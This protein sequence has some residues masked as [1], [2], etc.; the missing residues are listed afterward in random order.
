MILAYVQ[1]IKSENL[2]SLLHFLKNCMALTNCSGILALEIE[3]IP[4]GFIF[5]P[6]LGVE[7]VNRP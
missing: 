5:E 2:D 1:M 4:E 6:I 3:S 7:M